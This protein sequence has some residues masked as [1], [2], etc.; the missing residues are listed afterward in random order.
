MN[1]KTWTC[2]LLAAGALTIAGAPA[3]AQQELRIGF[4]APKT[5][6]FSQLGID[7]QNGFQ[8]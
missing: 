1:H 6:I 7:M 3:F 4:I 5:G 2:A 8:M